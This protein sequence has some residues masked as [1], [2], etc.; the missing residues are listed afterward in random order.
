MLEGLGVATI[1]DKVIAKLNS[2]IEGDRLESASGN[3]P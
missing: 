3:P 2:G 1:L